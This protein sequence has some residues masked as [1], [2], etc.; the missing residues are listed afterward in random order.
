MASNIL[1]AGYPLHVIA[2]RNR[3]PV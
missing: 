2:H 1:K 3:T